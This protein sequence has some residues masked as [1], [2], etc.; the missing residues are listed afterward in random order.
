MVINSCVFFT[1]ILPE[2]RTDERD[3]NARVCRLTLRFQAAPDSILHSSIDNRHSAA[4]NG[5]A[6][7]SDT[8]FQINVFLDPGVPEL[9]RVFFPDVSST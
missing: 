6:Y 8:S 2:P 4:Q 3:D 1:G 7:Q 9:L 5:R